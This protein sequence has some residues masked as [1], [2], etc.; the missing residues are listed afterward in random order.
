MFRQAGDLR[1]VAGAL[2]D[3]GLD[4]WER[5]DRVRGMVLVEQCLA[6]RRQSGDRHG[7]ARSLNVLGRLAFEQDD[8]MLAAA[9][10]RESL[11]LALEIGAR[12]WIVDGLEGMANVAGAA[13]QT[14][15]AV[16]LDAAAQVLREVIGKAIPPTRRDEYERNLARARAAL[17]E[18]LFVATWAE[19]LALSPE[20]AVADALA[21]QPDA[22][23]AAP[24]PGASSARP[25]GEPVALAPE[26]VDRNGMTP[27]EVEVLR[28]V[29]SGKSN[30][31]IAESL[32]VSI[33]TAE[34]HLA[35]IYAKLG[36][37]GPVARAVATAYAHTHGLA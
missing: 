12:E 26:P 4:A 23:E 33:R 32:V 11:P 25:L 3:V 30:S 5:G 24:G 10:Y 19:G 6:T 27:R 37:G 16:R 22:P 14:E 1:G 36:T 28:L 29:A 17:G 21:C 8:L 31:E 2:A 15:R 13:S 18:D 9:R 20:Q 7:V 35:N 34:R